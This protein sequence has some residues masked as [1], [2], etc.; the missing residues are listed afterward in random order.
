[1]EEDVL[2]RAKKKMVLE[3]ASGYHVSDSLSLWSLFPHHAHEYMRHPV[4]NQMDTSQAHLSSKGNTSV[5]DNGKPSDLSKDEL[6]AV[7]K[8]GAQKMCVYLFVSECGWPQ[9]S[10]AFSP[11]FDKDDNQQNQKLDNMDLDDILN[12]AEDHETL[13]SGGA[14]STSMGGEGFLSQFASVS[15]V[16][17]DMSWEDII[18]LKERQRLESEEEK[19]RTEEEVAAQARD[20]KRATVPVSYE[21]MDVDH[22][23]SS[24]A[25]KKPKA[26][27]PP[28]KTASQKAMELKERDIR[29]LIRSMQ[30]WGD[31]RQCYDV[32]VRN[33]F[34]RFYTIN[35]PSGARSQ[36]D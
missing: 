15:D 4:I 5:K 26:P 33:S 27:A 7:L 13:A 35:F 20:R 1:M 23:G 16:K 2:E 11:R 24:S 17:N 8:Y 30:R 22:A 10:F 9:P 36:T 14:G 21:G 3:Y 19:R 31:I 18:P 6:Q 28:R 32:I 34:A 25:P 12:H 29:V